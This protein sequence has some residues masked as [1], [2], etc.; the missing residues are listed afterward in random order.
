MILYTSHNVVTSPNFP[1]R[2][3]IVHSPFPKRWDSVYSGG[4][5]TFLKSTWRK[6]EPNPNSQSL[7]RLIWH[8]S[9]TA[10]VYRATTVW[11][12]IISDYC[13]VFFVFFLASIHEESSRRH[14]LHRGVD[15]Q[16]V[17]AEAEMS[18]RQFDCL[19]GEVGSKCCFH[20][21]MCVIAKIEGYML[22]CS[23]ACVPQKHLYLFKIAPYI[24]LLI[25]Y[26]HQM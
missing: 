13:L 14:V 18:L 19:W 8:Y 15:S 22:R 26:M 17:C 5:N 16:P 3:T 25:S 4:Q 23:Q 11:C 24:I 2:H 12:Q 10:C 21:R 1:A 6:P 20:V 9:N 7:A